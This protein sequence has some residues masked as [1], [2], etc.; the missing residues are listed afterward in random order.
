MLS[1]TALHA[2]YALFGTYTLQHLN[3]YEVSTHKSKSVTRF[4]A[5]IFFTDKQLDRQCDTTMWHAS[6]YI[7]TWL[8]YNIIQNLWLIRFSS[9]VC[10]AV[11][12]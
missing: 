8:H 7:T 1:N 10:L 5:S 11:A 12:T 3:I 6:G 9:L 2:C 4:S